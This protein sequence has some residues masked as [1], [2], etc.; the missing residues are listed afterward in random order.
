[1]LFSWR[2]LCYTMVIGGESMTLRRMLW[3]LTALALL[4]LTAAAYLYFREDAPHGPGNTADLVWEPYP[5]LPRSSV[6]DALL[7]RKDGFLRYGEAMVGVDVSSHQGA[8][9][10]ARVRASGVDFAILRVAYRGYTGGGLYL[11]PLFLDNLTAAREA[12]LQVGVYLFSQAV[13]VDEAEEEAR[14]LLDALDGAPLDLPVYFDW[15]YVE[16][17]AR[18]DGITRKQITQ[19]AVAFCDRIRLAGYVPGVYFNRNMAYTGLDLSQVDTCDFWL[20]RYQDTPDFPYEVQMW[21]YSDSG[22]VPG[23]SG[24]VDLNLRFVPNPE[25]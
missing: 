14:F 25:E 13:T 5:D 12:G 22:E 21:Q 1:M 7:Y 3:V 9:D 17:E 8:V 10:W 19:F 4:V 6:D 23:I 18:T 11:D 2:L 20:A 15:E 16:A 24:S